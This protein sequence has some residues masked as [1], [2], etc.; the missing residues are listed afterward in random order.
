MKGSIRVLARVRPLSKSEYAK[1]CKSNVKLP[2]ATTMT[3][4]LQ[5]TRGGTTKKEFQFDTCF[6]TTSTQSDVFKQ[7]APLVQSALDGY[8]VCIF[9]YGQTGSGKTYTMSGPGNGAECE[10]HEQGITPR[11]TQL[12]FDVAKENSGRFHVEFELSMIELYRGELQDLLRGKNKRAGAVSSLSKRTILE[13]ITS[14][15]QQELKS[16]PW[17]LG[18]LLATVGKKR[19]TASTLMNASSSRSHLV[20]TIRLNSTNKLPM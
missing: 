12:L 17:R 18:A 8:N 9:A 14:R 7:V 5:Q 2:D 13:Q 10:S 20:M 16:A 6:D 1:K 4:L 11:A 15:M 3:L 19:H